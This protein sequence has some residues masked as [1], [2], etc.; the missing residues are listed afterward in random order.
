MQRVH[1]PHHGFIID[2]FIRPEEDGGVF[3]RPSAVQ[4]RNNRF[5]CYRIVPQEHGLIGFHRQ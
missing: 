1:Y 4:S 5:I 2:R 3:H